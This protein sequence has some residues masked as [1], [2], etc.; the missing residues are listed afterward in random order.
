[1]KFGT[2]RKRLKEG[3][4]LERFKHFALQL[5]TKIHVTLSAIGKP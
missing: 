4:I 1:V 5:L 2:Y 3:E